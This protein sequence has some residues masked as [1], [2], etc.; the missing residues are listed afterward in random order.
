[1]TK[2]V[3]GVALMQLWEQGRFGLDDPL[4][5]HLPQFADV[6]VYDEADPDKLRPPSRKITIRGVAQHVADGALAAPRHP[7]DPVR[8]EPLPL[9]P[10]LTPPHGARLLPPVPLPLHP[11][12]R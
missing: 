2:P 11:A 3:T 9:S 1:M 12:P 5:R 7:T 6:Q 4:E 10:P 8:H